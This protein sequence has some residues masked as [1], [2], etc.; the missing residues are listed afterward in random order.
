MTLRGATALLCMLLAP[1]A[2]AQ[3]EQYK[4]PA[5]AVANFD[6]APWEEQKA[7]L[8]KPPRP[9]DLIRFEAGPRRVHTFDYFVDAASLTVDPDGVVRYTVVARSA[10]ASNISYEGI[11]CETA[12]RKIYAY[13]R[14]D[15][16][17]YQPRDPSWARF[18]NAAAEGFRYTLYQDY[19]CPARLGI[20]SAAEGI[21]A[22]RRGG[23]PHAVD[24][25]D[26]Q[27]LRR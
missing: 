20:K 4:D 16:T 1:A 14:P 19:F 26:Q 5:A 12:E 10:S 17:W 13:A 27:P 8:P 21:A 22:L 6:K 3:F 25:T 18:G 2:M 7:R 11:R 9:E 24:L 23:H 15:G